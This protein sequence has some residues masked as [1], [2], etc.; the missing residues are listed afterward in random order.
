[1]YRRINITLP[2]ETVRLMDRGSARG[3]RSRLI[4]KAVKR[5]VAATGRANLGRR[6]KQGAL[7]R[8]E[9]DLQ[10][11]GESFFLEEEA[12]SASAR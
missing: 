7:R 1:M 8:A 4:D 9:G 5:Y 2:E 12:W 10:L 3:G 11:A 6:V